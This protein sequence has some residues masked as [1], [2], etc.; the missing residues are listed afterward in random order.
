M[1]NLKKN[2]KKILT[3]VT[4]TAMAFSTVA[5]ALAMPNSVKV[6]RADGSVA[7]YLMNDAIMNPSLL[8]QM[9]NDVTSAFLSSRPMVGILSSGKVANLQ[10]ELGASSTSAYEAGVTAGTTAAGTDLTATKNVT[11]AGGVVVETPVT[12]ATATISSVSPVTVT[13]VAG[14]APVL[15]AT[16]TATMSDATTTTPA[17]TWGA[18]TASQYA[19]AGTFAVTGTVAGTTQTA[20]ANVTV[21]TPAV[22]TLA[23]SSITP[24]NLRQVQVVFNEAVD[25]T[26]AE[27]SANY[28]VSITDYDFTAGGTGSTT[29]TNAKLQADGKTVILTLTGFYANQKSN[30]TLAVSNVK[31]LTGTVLSSTYNA[32]GLTYVDATIP[33][34]TGV[35][36]VGPRTIEI[37][38]S[39]PVGKG[40]IGD[41]LMSDTFATSDFSVDSGAVGVSGATATASANKISLTL[42]A[43]LPAG[44]HSI[45]VNALAS[46]Q[47]TD[48][49]GLPIVKSTQTF[50]Q[51]LAA[52]APTVSVLKATP[53]KVT[54]QF[55]VPVTN[56]TAATFYHDFP[57]L[58]SSSAT[59]TP[60]A[61]S[62]G[63]YSDQ[64]DINFSTNF[65]TGVGNLYLKNI[66]GSEIKDRYGNLLPDAT[67]PYTAIADKTLP[68]VASITASSTKVIKV[69]FSKDMNSADVVNPSYYTFKDSNGNV[70]TTSKVQDLDFY[71]HPGSGV[72]PVYDPN[73][74]TVT[75]TF[76]NGLIAGA[77]Q[78][79]TN[80]IQ[81]SLT[82]T[83]NKLA[84][85]T[86]SF[87]VV[88]TTAMAI[89]TAFKSGNNVIVTYSRPIAKS[90]AGSALDVS[91]YQIQWGGAG[92]GNPV[93]L[94]TGST[95]ISGSSA[96]QVI[97]TLASTT[98]YVSTTTL[99]ASAANDATGKAID[100]LHNSLVVT[101][102]LGLLAADI[103]NVKLLNKGSF[104]FE[105]DQPLLSVDPAKIKVNAVAVDT[106]SFVNQTLSDGTSYGAVVTA[107]ITT[108]ANYLDTI[109]KTNKLS[110]NNTAEPLTF[111]IGA[112]TDLQSVANAGTITNVAVVKDYAP[113]TYTAITQSTGTDGVITGIKATFSEDVLAG[114]ISAS[115]FNVAGYTVT[116]L[117]PHVTN[118]PN[119]DYV[120]IVVSKKSTAD[121]GAIPVVTLVQPVTDASAQGNVEAIQ[122]AATA[123]TSVDGVAPVV[124]SAVITTPGTTAGFGNDVNDIL[125]LTFSEPV[126]TSFGV[127][128]APTAAELDALF[129]GGVA[130]LTASPFA[131]GVFT[132]TDLSTTSGTKLVITE[133]GGAMTT[134]LLTGKE[135]GTTTAATLKDTAGNQLLNTQAVVTVQ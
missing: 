117:I 119:V 65:L 3:L 64:W 32:T 49:A 78:L 123:V 133:T 38:F 2:S 28:T 76:P 5:P 134:T 27:T 8:T 100:S 17:V 124:T 34:I 83:S 94:P 48:Y 111:A 106:A 7:N 19:A 10:A 75:W 108:P 45:V 57:N 26:S 97:I 67:L 54:L 121:S 1:R 36:S 90:G 61:N 71:G 104:S 4:A 12:V 92:V 62:D 112:L 89:S 80:N 63:T 13:T 9:T 110:I 47:F 43:D 113:P 18:V 87:S 125:T 74:Y 51:T 59:P 135:I 52:T 102:D 98:G 86:Q 29:V 20:T 88:D 22:T 84:D 66:V 44:S 55:S 42:S 30:Q 79:E 85:N 6:T 70:L 115:S 33:V 118:A 15:P 105:V 41:N 96:N 131:G 122:T 73:S 120:T 68:T 93:P 60:G 129:L 23:V 11:V 58:T 127:A 56:V 53:T 40:T 37:T 130:G 25:K 103:K 132:A 39:E 50:T 24:L 116:N 35:A 69:R 91:N 95:I 72:V 21:T 31:D 99:L 101:D 114:S 81:D 16:V 109:V 107:N 128:T 82:Y 46:S 77:Y 126:K 14:T